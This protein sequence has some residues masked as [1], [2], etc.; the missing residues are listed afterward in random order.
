MK[1]GY[2]KGFTVMEVLLTTLISS[3]II[4]MVYFTYVSYTQQLLLFQ[5][6]VEEKNHVNRFLFQLKTDFF[7]SEKVL[8]KAEAFQVVFYD[9]KT[10]DYK[11]RDGILFR[12]ENG[13]K[14]SIQ[15]LTS[16]FETLTDDFH[17]QELV[18][19][20]SLNASLFNKP[21]EFVVGK[22]YPTLIQL[23]PDHGH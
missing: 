19:L 18:R 23:N 4:G 16:S 9:T 6:G 5:N 13:Q 10:I 17:Q 20:A 7:N 21:L 22:D 11:I 8:R 12:E 2:T 15:V 3:I 14:D 1:K